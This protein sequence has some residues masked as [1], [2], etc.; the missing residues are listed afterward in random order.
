MTQYLT[1][2]E[3][4]GKSK[5]LFENATR[6]TNK[7]RYLEALGYYISFAQAGQNI[8]MLRYNASLYLKQAA[9]NLSFGYMDNVTAL[10]QNF[11]DIETAYE[12]EAQQYNDYRGQIDG[13][14]FFSEIREIP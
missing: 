1:S 13:Y 6:F 7:S 5:P 11:T 10:L 3:K 14:L 9:E 12:G 2:Y 8:T 4:F